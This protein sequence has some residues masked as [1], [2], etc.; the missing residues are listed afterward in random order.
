MAGPSFMGGGSDQIVEV[1]A[2]WS[3]VLSSVSCEDDCPLCCSSP[4][5]CIGTQREN[6]R[7]CH[8][9]FDSGLVFN[10]GAQDLGLGSPIGSGIFVTSLVVATGILDV[11]CS[12][13]SVCLCAAGDAPFLSPSYSMKANLCPCA[14]AVGSR[15]L[16]LSDHKQTL[17]NPSKIKSCH[18]CTFIKKI[19]W[20]FLLVMEGAKTT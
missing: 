18:R 9:C 6:A 19:G 12:R 1:W 17:G 8:D 15:C 14:A 5:M 11:L 10:K 16:S 7:S 3:A 4:S 20:L 2:Q 13:C